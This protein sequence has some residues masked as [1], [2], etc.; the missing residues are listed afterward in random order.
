MN[1]DLMKTWDEMNGQLFNFINQQVQDADLAK[2]LV[3]DVFIKVYSKIDTLK[4]TEKIV[5]WIYQITRN[6]IISNFRKQKPQE[7]ID[8]PIEMENLD[9]NLTVEFSKCMLPMIS[10]LPAKYRQAIELV[11][12][13]DIPPKQLAE[14]LGISYSGAKS[15][16]QRGREMLKMYLQ[17]CCTIATDAYGTVIDYKAK[18]CEDNC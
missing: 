8:K 14:Q 2:D 5:P 17:E 10:S 1:K 6:E 18:K 13:K 12:L 9:N 15:R 16:V 4:N 7:V 11:E 3:Q